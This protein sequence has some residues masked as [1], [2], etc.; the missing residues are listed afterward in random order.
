VTV[1]TVEKEQKQEELLRQE[2]LVL[3]QLKHPNILLLMGL[4]KENPPK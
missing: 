1:R 4:L 2:L 3:S